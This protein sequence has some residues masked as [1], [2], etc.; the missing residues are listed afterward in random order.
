MVCDFAVIRQHVI[1]YLGDGQLFWQFH[2]TV[3]R[4]LTNF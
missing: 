2:G 4:T 1:S 3:Y